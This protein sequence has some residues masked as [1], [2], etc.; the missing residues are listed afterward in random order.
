MIEV[1]LVVTHVHHRQ[2]RAAPSPTNAAIRIETSFRA[3]TPGVVSLF[4]RSGAGKSSLVLAIAGLLRPQSG[5]IVIDGEVLFDSGRGIDLPAE[6]R[7]TGV[8]FQ[9]GRLFPHL[10]VRRNLEY[11]LVRARRAGGGSS[12]SLP[13]VSGVLGLE[14]LLARAP[15][16]LSG[17]ERQRVALGRALLAQPRLLLLD[18]PLA[19]LDDE[20]KAEVLHY[21]QQVRDEF[22]VPMIHVSHSIDEVARLATFVVQIDGGRTLAAAP[23]TAFPRP[24]V[25]AG[26][27]AFDPGTIIAGQLV[28]VEGPAG[29]AGP[30]VLVV[31]AGGFGW[32]PV[33]FRVAAGAGA[34]PF[35]LGDRLR[36]RVR[37]EDVLLA[38]EPWPQGQG[39][40]C[41]EGVVA[42]GAGDDAS[43]PGSVWSS[44]RRLV[45]GGL[46]LR[47]AAG[48]SP[49]A[50]VGEAWRG[51]EPA[52]ALVTRCELLGREPMAY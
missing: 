34:L 45:A 41:F 44:G 51:G 2:H 26:A 21:L 40:A 36:L 20:R 30:E 39:S 48:F 33:R 24:L 6:R 27:T 23:L 50:L 14:P 19:A 28:A 10:D 31:E 4:G 1:D 18:E 12:I 42:A 5:R 7:R 29:G 52:H 16:T 15:W 9:D 3:V 38:S 43:S 37:P 8:V 25:D 49:A 11:G 13:V 35:A 46:A 32:P 47:A 22:R 17:G